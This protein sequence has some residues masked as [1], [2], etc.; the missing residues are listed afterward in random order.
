MWPQRGHAPQIENHVLGE[1]G[2]LPC[3]LLVTTQVPSTENTHC[4]L[5]SSQLL[6]GPVLLREAGVYWLRNWGSGDTQS[7]LLPVDFEISMPPFLTEDLVTAAGKSAPVIVTGGA[8]P[9]T[10]STKQKQ[11]KITFICK[12]SE[13]I[14]GFHSK[15]RRSQAPDH[16]GHTHR[17]W[18]EKYTPVQWQC[19]RVAHTS[20]RTSRAETNLRLKPSGNS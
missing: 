4:V 19:Y 13:K 8:A 20:K 16:R 9:P 5:I 17:E 11:C 15:R 18:L 3:L 14:T 7:R 6:W 1:R 10:G 2:A 12:S